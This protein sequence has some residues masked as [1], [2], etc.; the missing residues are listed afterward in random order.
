MLKRHY[1]VFAYRP[2]PRRFAVIFIDITERKQA[3]MELKQTNSP[4]RKSKQ[5]DG[6]LQLLRFPR[7]ARPL[8]AIDGYARMILKQQADR[9]D[10]EARRQ[11]NLIRDNRA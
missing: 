10:E 5:G 1:E 9:F 11:F 7:S 8:R 3:E 6:K 2:A 4:P